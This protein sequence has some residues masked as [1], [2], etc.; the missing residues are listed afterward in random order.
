MGVYDPNLVSEFE[1]T[2][3][4]YLRKHGVVVEATTIDTVTDFG[5]LG[6]RGADAEAA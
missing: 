4:G 2:P 3:D 5:L 6:S 1:L